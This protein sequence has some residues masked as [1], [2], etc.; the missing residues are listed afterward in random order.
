MAV[1]QPLWALKLAS[2][3]QSQAVLQRDKPIRVWGEAEPGATVE[4][5]L[6]EESGTTM[7]D[8]DGHWEVTLGALPAGGPYELSA[9]SGDTNVLLENILIGDV[10]VCSGQS[11]MHW[12][13]SKSM[14]APE[15]MASANFPSIR[16]FNVPGTKA[17]E[18]ARYA[19]G[20][21]QICSPDTVPECSAVAYY[22]AREQWKTHGVP[23]GLIIASVGATPI[24]CWLSEAGYQSHP[25]LLEMAA[26]AELLEAEPELAGSIFQKRYLKWFEDNPVFDVEPKGTVASAFLDRDNRT[27][28]RSIRQPIYIER[29]DYRQ[30]GIYWLRTRRLLPSDW[31][32]KNLVLHISRIDDCDV[33]YV[34][35]VR[36]GATGFEE[37][38]EPWFASRAYPIP[39]HVNDRKEIAINIRVL[40]ILGS[41]GIPEF[42]SIYLCPEDAAD[43]RMDLS[44]PWELKVETELRAQDIPPPPELSRGFSVY[45]NGMVAPFVGF[46]VKGFLWYQGET[47]TAVPM[48][49]EP[50]FKAFIQDW[51]T[52]WGDPGLPFLYVQLASFEPLGAL[53]PDP[54]ENSA[55]ALLRESQTSALELPATEMAT[56]LDIGSPVDIHPPNKQEVGRRLSLCADKVG[57]GQAV[58]CGGPR[59]ADMSI[60]GERVL[61]RFENTGDGLRCKASDIGGFVM[62]GDDRNFHWADAQIVDNDTVVISSKEVPEPVSVRYA[63][64]DNPEWANLE[65]SDGLPAEPF[66]TDDWYPYQATPAVSTSGKKTIGA[67]E[68]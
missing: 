63:W 59:L 33:T 62:A 65:N 8:S 40:E 3:F 54:N 21:W 55:W 11:N 42:G 67:S 25:R 66:R 60:D 2:P 45:Y 10:W 27:G 39:A 37:T 22:F 9:S 43:E 30:P 28:W 32:G 64:A 24:Q 58:L 13:V 52:L 17:T 4:V 5:I 49:Y 31:R 38:A 51:R 44:G 41:G 1:A 61:L 12:P 18:P 15:E 53:M 20:H 46:A 56:T 23:V 35:G 36:V 29:Y 57:H 7:A 68:N 34:N 50:L 26:E 14:N 47:N 16:L 48:E 19:K 6:S